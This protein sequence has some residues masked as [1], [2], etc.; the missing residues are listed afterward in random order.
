MCFVA[1]EHILNRTHSMSTSIVV[2]ADGQIGHGKSLAQACFVVRRPSF[3]QFYIETH[4]DIER[5]KCSAS[6][7]RSSTGS[8]DIQDKYGT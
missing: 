5:D 7:P 4:R 3:T 1:A 8:P 2:G 6:L